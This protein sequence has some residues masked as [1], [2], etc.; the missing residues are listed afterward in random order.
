MIDTICTR[1][2]QLQDGYFKCGSGPETIFVLGSC[3]TL[4]FLNYL[5][6]WNT[7]EGN[8]RFTIYRI[9]VCDT[10]WNAQGQMIDNAPILAAMETDERILSVL[11]NATIF[12][13]EHLGNY[14]MFN[15]SRDAEKNIYQFGMT[16]PIDISIPNWH[17]VFCLYNDF[18]E[19]NALTDDWAQKGEAAIQKVVDLC[20]LTSFPEMGDYIKDNWRNIRFFWRANHTSA[21]FTLKIFRLMNEKFLHLPLSDEFWAGA[22]TE[23]MFRDPHTTVTQQDRDAYGITW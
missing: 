12:I 13:H 18:V 15:T 3:R 22:A 5:N 21:A 9:D 6:R 11:R 4:A 7:T 17:D 19:F 1:Q 23:D 10:N 16:A 2:G 8:N 14:G 20:P